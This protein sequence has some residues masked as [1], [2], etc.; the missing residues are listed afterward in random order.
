MSTAILY[1]NDIHSRIEPFP[2]NDPKYANQGGFARRAAVIEE[3][4]KELAEIKERNRRVELDKAWE[5][6]L[7]RKSL[8]AVL[9]C[10]VV[11]VFFY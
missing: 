1:T 4:K 9:T 3:I 7:A 11:V 10:V 2:S 6:S 8:I 5:T